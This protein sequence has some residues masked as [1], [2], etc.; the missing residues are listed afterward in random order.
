MGDK[1]TEVTGEDRE[2]KKR[3]GDIYKKEG[4]GKVECKGR[5]FKE[6]AKLIW[7]DSDMIE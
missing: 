7:Q 4:R 3:T 6:G 5:N 2:I 1:E